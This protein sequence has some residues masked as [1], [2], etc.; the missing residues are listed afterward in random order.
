MGR[1]TPTSISLAL[2]V[3]AVFLAL[4]G[5]LTLIGSSNSQYSDAYTKEMRYNG[6]D[7][8]KSEDCVIGTCWCMVCK[9]NTKIFPGKIDLVGQYCFFDK[10]CDQ[11]QFNKYANGT[12][13]DFFL[14]GFGIGTGLTFTDFA[15]ANK[16]CSER[17]NIAV[18]W[19]VGTD[20]EPYKIPDAGRAVCMLSKDIM[21][22]YVLYS[23]YSKG[24]VLNTER[25]R[26]IANTLFTAGALYTQGKLSSGPVGPVVITTEIDFDKKDA[27]AIAQQVK[28]I[29]DGCMNKRNSLTDPKATDEIYC[30]VAVAPKINDYEALDAVMAQP[31]M[32][33]QVDLVA[34]GINGRYVETCDPYRIMEQ[35]KN[36]S[37]YA[38]YKYQKPTIIP[39]V[40]FEPAGTDKL[41]TCEWNEN[42]VRNAYSAVFQESVT[43]LTKKGVIAIAPY[44]F[45]STTIRPGNPLNCVDCALAKND[46][47]MRTWFGQCQGYTN[48]VRKMP[49]QDVSH[50]TPTTMILFSN[51]SAGYCD[52]N[53]NPDFLRGM[54]FGQGSDKSF[55]DPQLPNLAQASDK[56][57]SCDA[58]LV[59][60]STAPPWGSMSGGGA[61]RALAIQSTGQTIDACTSMPEID[62][63][64]EQRDLDPMLVRAFILTESGFDPC[65]YAV[66]M[67]P[68]APMS[69][70]PVPWGCFDSGVATYGAGY[71]F[72]DY[73]GTCS[74]AMPFP[75]PYDPAIMGEPPTTQPKWRFLGLGLMGSL[76]A[77]YTFWPAKY[78][79]E[80]DNGQYWKW[81]EP[82]VAMDKPL[83]G[84]DKVDGLFFEQVPPASQ[85]AGS[86][87]LIS[88]RILAAAKDCNPDNFNPFNV[89]DS[90]C[91]G[92]WK[93]KKALDVGRA[94]VRY[95]HSMGWITWS[96]YDKD[97]ALAAYLAAN[98]YVGGWGGAGKCG[99]G[100]GADCAGYY[101]FQ[102]T[103]WNDVICAQNP[104]EGFCTPDGK[105]DTANCYGITDFPAAVAC[106]HNKPSPMLPADNGL[107]KIKAYYGL[108]TGCG[109]DST[110]PEGPKLLAAMNQPPAAGTDVY[111]P[112]APVK[113]AVPPTTPP[114][115]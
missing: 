99:L 93:M 66:V 96:D 82:L 24:G 52:F 63:W 53:S 42:S 34:F 51:A 50:P 72:M 115:Q 55:A 105:A 60:S 54:T 38:L 94:K 97:A 58:C 81:L 25:P 32:K 107:A 23:N 16:Y 65:K 6:T 69:L 7:F 98:Y 76:E 43:S 88:E 101:Y 11:T 13:K 48:I 67:A 102:S 113:D 40:M 100:D 87:A 28:A 1:T 47:R 27:A 68:N 59:R 9:N 62:L 106:W 70:C 45:N 86:R 26:K 90:L 109:K 79:K 78:R 83:P 56:L 103:R 39:Y 64:A 112:G 85:T 75:I 49:S 110:C 74:G 46:G 111:A 33:D 20:S 15:N 37:K 91:M 30:F 14:R 21:P 22:V 8:N 71:D 92:T 77:P 35:V 5:C 44:S 61:P 80:N 2:I 108:L 41:N 95:F 12:Y 31:G 73:A 3:I 17:M 84:E 10:N 29:N 18:Q 57:I 114:T 104:V 4:P 19:L 36:F 89:S